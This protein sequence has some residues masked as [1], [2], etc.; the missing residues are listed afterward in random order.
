MFIWSLRW[1]IISCGSTLMLDG[2]GHPWKMH[3]VNTER[4]AIQET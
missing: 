3:A 4:G 1:W 2:A